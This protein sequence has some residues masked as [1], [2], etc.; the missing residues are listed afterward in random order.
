MPRVSRGGGPAVIVSSASDADET[1]GAENNVAAIRRTSTTDIT[2]T[3]PPPLHND[4][5]HGDVRDESEGEDGIVASAAVATNNRDVSDDIDIAVTPATK[6]TIAATA[7]AAATE[8]QYVTKKDGT[9]EL[10]NKEK[11]R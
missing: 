5:T 3:P 7:A 6:I 9:M 1:N 8:I 2:A 10:F 4:T 11:V